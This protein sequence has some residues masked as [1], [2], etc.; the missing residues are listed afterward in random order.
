VPAHTFSDLKL[1]AEHRPEVSRTVNTDHT[2]T[3]EELPGFL[4]IGVVLDGVR[5][6]LFRLKAGGFL[7]DLERHRA[8]QAAAQAQPPPGE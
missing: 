8:A 3:E 4:H 2:V 7:A 1:Y 6:E 5:K